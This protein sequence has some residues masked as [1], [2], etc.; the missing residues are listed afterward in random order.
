M[1]R[2][3]VS[4]T[5]PTHPRFVMRDAL[6]GAKAVSPVLLG[7]APF[8]TIAGIA[9]VEI[10]F[11]PWQAIG[12]S[13]IVFAGAAQ[14][15][16]IALIG[17]GAN[18]LVV[19]LT[20]AVINLRF[21]MYSASIAPYFERLGVGVKALFA[22]LLT[23]Q[24]YAVAVTRFREAEPV[25]R[26]SYYSGAAL[27]MWGTWQ[28][29]TAAGALLGAGVPEGWSL[30]FA[31]PL[32]FIALLVPNVKDRPSLFA[33]LLG[34]LAAVALRGLPYNIG[35]IVAALSGVTGGVWA[36]RWSVEP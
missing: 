22:Y 13:L 28:L 8:A 11:T 4:E 15:A 12:M 26:G 35:L 2:E 23:D 5:T 32:T 17:E 19:I 34:G 36:A 30:D 14:L 10:G 1:S 24:A 7:V 9:G 21:M 31:I 33:A 16:G 25:A 18:A 3:T 20:A 6:A 27:A 29:G